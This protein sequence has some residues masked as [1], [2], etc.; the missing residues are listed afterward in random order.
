MV[1]G[2]LTI[3]QESLTEKI[4]KQF[5]VTVGRNTPLSTDVFPE[6]PDG[7]CPIRELSGS[8]V[9][10]ANQTRPDISNAVRER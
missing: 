8:L 9:W 3:S 5:G 10:L 4:V 6:E 7:V 2:L 1:A